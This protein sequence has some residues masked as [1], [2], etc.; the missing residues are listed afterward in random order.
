MRPSSII[1]MFPSSLFIV[2]AATS[3]SS[4]V[5]YQTAAAQVEIN[6]QGEE[7]QGHPYHQDTTTTAADMQC[8]LWLAPST[9][10]GAGLGMFAGI[11]Y[12][13]GQE[14]LG[15]GDSVIAIV[16]LLAHNGH[17]EYGAFL[18]DEYTWN[19]KAL[20]MDSEGYAEVNAASEGFGAAVNCILPIYNVEEWFPIN[21]DLHLHRS[22][23]PG[24]GGSTTFHQRKSTAKR[25]I[26]P[27]EELLVSCA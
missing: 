5:L 8:G 16:D 11:E 26:A 13:Q 19:G 6:L 14:L 18:W 22:A 24:A 2:A 20:K 1:M 17:A 25:P 10:E 15:G 12:E 23:D 3:S 7:L 4:S 21:T 9:I 27:G